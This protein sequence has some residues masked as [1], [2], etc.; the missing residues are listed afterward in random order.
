M[1]KE[2]ISRVL[3]YYEVKS[4]VDSIYGDWV[5]SKAGDIVNI[6]RRY[7]IYSSQVRDDRWLLH[8]RDK[9][10]FERTSF[11][12]AFHRACEILGVTVTLKEDF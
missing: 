6:E 12:A 1:E 3:D 5:V 7:P 10:W 4:G 9:T 2:L 8:L 11:L